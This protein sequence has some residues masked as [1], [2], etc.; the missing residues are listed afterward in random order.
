M[1]TKPS[2]A[3][4]NSAPLRSAPFLARQ[5][6]RWSQKETMDYYRAD[7]WTTHGPNILAEETQEKIRHHLEKLG[8]LVI[9]HK[10]FCGARAPTP[11]G[12]DDYDEFKEYLSAHVCP[13]DKILIWPFPDGD[14]LFGGMY[15]ND[16]GEVPIKGAY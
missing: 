11:L 5:G 1:P 13:G 9:L 4:S 2:T 6:G 10:H 3:A 16:K 12:F 14:P 15:P 8:Y 7:N